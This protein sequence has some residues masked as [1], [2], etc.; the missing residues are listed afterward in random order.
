MKRFWIC[1]L[2]SLTAVCAIAEKKG[3]PDKDP[4]VF[5]R[6]EVANNALKTLLQPQINKQIGRKPIMTFEDALDEAIEKSTSLKTARLELKSMIENVNR[7]QYQYIP[8]FS[9]EVDPAY[10]ERTYETTSTREKNGLEWKGNATLKQHL[11]S[12]IDIT[13]RVQKSY[14][15]NGYEV[16]TL[17]LVIE[18][19][20]LRPDPISR[21][22]SLARLQ[23]DLEHIS[24]EQT[25]R[26]FIYEFK[27]AYYAYL[28][29][30]LVYLNTRLKF[31][32][33][34][35]LNDE[36]QRKYD[37]GIIAQY[38][39]LDYD[40]DFTESELA[41]ASDE[42]SWK[43]ARNR[44]LTLLHRPLNDSIQFR[45]LEDAPTGMEWDAA[46]MLDVAMHSSLDVARFNT[47]LLS[48]E[49]NAD[50]YRRHLR[51]SVSVFA[52]GS[53]ENSDLASTTDREETMWST[54]LKVIMP[55]FQ[56]RFI[57]RSQVRTQQNNIDI[58]TL[59]LEERFRYYQRQ[60]ADDLLQL[61]DLH[62]RYEL[63]KKQFRIAF[64]DYELGKLRFENG[65][66]GSWDMIRNKNNFFRANETCIQLQYQLLLQIA[67]LE[68]DYPTK[69]AEPGDSENE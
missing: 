37:A 48:S 26:N 68:R 35:R 10:T 69:P 55:L 63:S 20:M 31:Q 64:A 54:G 19:E 3:T 4:L 15:D 13:G 11:P 16:E 56:S 28:R 66:I 24:E 44:L 1:I 36:S 25:R 5:N 17:S 49:I 51:P 61:R 43:T 8:A 46:A 34:R 7:A 62:Q 58:N 32:D 47:A 59:E 53:R 9:I 42:R 33:N 22:Q 6:P 65:T 38:Q 2:V 12:N 39:L 67:K 40:R 50:Y 18:K 45:P 41:L 52:S 23:L 27:S 30:W 60:V 29:E 14:N 57:D 21:T